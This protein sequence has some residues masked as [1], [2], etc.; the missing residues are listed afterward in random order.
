MT[1]H[2]KIVSAIQNK[3]RMVLLYKDAGDSAP[4]ERT[5]DAWVFG[6]ALLASGEK[7]PM[8]GGFFVGDHVARIRM[9]RVHD[10][11]MLLNEAANPPTTPTNV[12][13]KRWQWEN[14]YAEWK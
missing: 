6:E 2:D 5:F 12:S 9:D 1:N 11:K 4:V 14:V 10:V 7:Q 13:N 8:I 3:Q